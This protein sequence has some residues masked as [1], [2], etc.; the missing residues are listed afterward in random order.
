MSKRNR[1]QS[2]LDSSIADPSDFPQRE[3]GHLDSSLTCKICREFYRGPVSLSCGHCFCSLCI[4]NSMTSKQECPVCRKCANEGQIRPVAALEEIVESWK[5]A[6]ALVLTLATANGESSRLTPEESISAIAGPST[7]NK[8]RKLVS[9]DGLIDCPICHTF[10]PFDAINMHIDSGCKSTSTPSKPK[11][12]AE[13]S[14]VFSKRSKDS[15]QESDPDRR[16]PKLNYHTMKEKQ[17]RELLSQAEL[18]TAG[19]KNALTARHQQW[20]ILYNSNQD[21]SA[22]QRQDLERIRKELKKWEAEGKARKVDI[23]DTDEYQR[24]HKQ[25][26]IELIERAR[27]SR[28]HSHKP[29][30]SRGREGGSPIEEPEVSEVTD[31][32]EVD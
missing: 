29:Q 32:I 21:R 30:S 16:L 27:R 1:L 25:D 14:K 26:F 7:P 6:R 8:R 22:S 15:A 23:D 3:L 2:L 9:E 12:K 13:W 18:S 17:I 10:V 19:D 4:R 20:T 11:Q 5:A 24:L 31:P 28:F